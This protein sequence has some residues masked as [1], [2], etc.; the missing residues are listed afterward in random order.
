MSNHYKI[1]ITKSIVRILGGVLAFIFNNLK[2][3]CGFFVLA[4]FIGI[5]E[6]K[7]ESK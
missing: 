1:S 2:V 7:Y 6:E 3:L 5:L 4:E